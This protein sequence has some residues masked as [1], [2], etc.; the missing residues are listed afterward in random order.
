MARRLGIRG[1]G[2]RA[3][4]KTGHVP[5]LNGPDDYADG[6]EMAKRAAAMAPTLGFCPY[7]GGDIDEANG[8]K[9]HPECA[10][11]DDRKCFHEYEEHEGYRPTCKKCGRAKPV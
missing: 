3:W 8:K 2:P 6:D 7:C 9:H 10:V 4:K 11:T 5:V 1:S